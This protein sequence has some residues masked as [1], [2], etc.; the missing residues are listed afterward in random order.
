MVMAAGITLR[1]VGALILLYA[2]PLTWVHLRHPGWSAVLAAALLAETVAV[3]CVWLWQRRIGALTL[4]VDVP[5]GVLALFAGAA[6]NPGHTGS[7]LN[8]V[9][10]Y[11]I[12]VTVTLGL[13]DRPLWLGLLSG[14]VLLAAFAV[15]RL[16]ADHRLFLDS[17]SLGT[18]YLGNPMVGWLSARALRRSMAVLAAAQA[19]DAR[20]AAQVAAVQVRNRQARALHDRLLQTLEVLARG[21]A[22]PDPSL[23]AR[24][25]EQAAW[26]RRF[27]ETGLVDQDED[28]PAGLAAAVRA[29]ARDGIRVRLY[30]AQLRARPDAGALDGGP[31]EALVHAVYQAISCIA[32]NGG[33]VAVRAVPDGEGVQVTLVADRGAVPDADEVSELVARLAAVGGTVTADSV[34]YVRLRVPIADPAASTAAPPAVR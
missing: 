1:A 29:A 31:R 24:V 2:V 6:L 34:P 3:V 5:A 4:A 26:L 25:T 22:I 23:R 15:S 30:D 13:S 20:Q 27:I 32:G 28:L 7:W 12:F 10:P 8:F 11:T 9:F 17:I 16:L 14:T 21:T 19:D 33:T 18:S